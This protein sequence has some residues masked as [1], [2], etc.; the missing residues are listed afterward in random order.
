MPVITY[1]CCDCS[2]KFCYN[3]AFSTHKKLQ[4]P[5]CLKLNIKY[6]GVA[7]CIHCGSSSQYQPPSVNPGSFVLCT[8]CGGNGWIQVLGGAIISQL[9]N[10]RFRNFAVTGRTKCS[11]GEKLKVSNPFITGT[12][13]DW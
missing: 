2:H 8:K 3:P 9:P 1:E 4:C 12:K 5:G 7:E 13:R 10:T 11:S 6:A